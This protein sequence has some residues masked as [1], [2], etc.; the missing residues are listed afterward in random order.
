[1]RVPIRP[2]YGSPDGLDYHGESI[3][4][5]PGTPQTGR[6]LLAMGIN[7]S[8]DDEP[9]CYHTDDAYTGAPDWDCDWC[10]GDVRVA[11]THEDQVVFWRPQGL[12]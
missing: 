11:V 5:P 7:P 4:A 10:D 12:Q 8:H 9:T 1:M 3:A 6:D 2:A